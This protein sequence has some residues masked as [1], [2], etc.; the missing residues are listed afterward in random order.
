MWGVWR[1]KSDQQ[2]KLDEQAGKSL[3]SEMGLVTGKKPGY[4]GKYDAA[5]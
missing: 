1:A 4:V 2:R 3:N 5:L